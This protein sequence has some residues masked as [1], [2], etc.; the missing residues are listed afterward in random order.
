MK[1]TRRVALLAT[2]VKI[3]PV[4]DAGR[5]RPPSAPECYT[6]IGCAPIGPLREALRHVGTDRAWLVAVVR[7]QDSLTSTSADICASCRNW[8]GHRR[9]HPAR[10]SFC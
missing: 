4:N 5:V 2:D 1:T 7:D 6:L 8:D 10:K 9:S 3:N